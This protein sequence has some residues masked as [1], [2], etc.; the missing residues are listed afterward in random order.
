MAKAI[1][2]AMASL[3]VLLFMAGA[4]F[5]CQEEYGDGLAGFKPPKA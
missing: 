3:K 2:A 1:R 5:D 4:L